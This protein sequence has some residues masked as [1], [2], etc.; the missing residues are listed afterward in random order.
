METI[1]LLAQK[2][3]TMDQMMA[4]DV[5]LAAEKLLKDLLVNTP[6]NLHVSIFVEMENECS[7]KYV[8]TVI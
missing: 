2:H 6:Q 4:L 5:S 7:L 3:V 8:T 1:S